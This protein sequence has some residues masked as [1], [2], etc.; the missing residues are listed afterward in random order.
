MYRT[1]QFVCYNLI[2][3]FLKKLKT[4]IFITL[5]SSHRNRKHK[6]CKSKQITSFSERKYIST[7]ANINHNSIFL[8]TAVAASVQITKCSSLGFLY[9]RDD[10]F[11]LHL[12]TRYW[13]HSTCTYNTIMSKKKPTS[14]HLAA[15]TL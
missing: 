13:I 9:L 4:Q 14:L 7:L 6:T 10:Y 11:V 3:W 2:F 5:Y 12:L 8:N 1:Y 15:T